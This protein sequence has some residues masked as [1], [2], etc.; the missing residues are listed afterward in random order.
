M[1]KPQRPKDG[2]FKPEESFGYMINYV[3]RLYAREMGREAARHGVQL[4]TFPVLL[5]L[6]EA[7]GQTQSEL[8]V[9]AQIEQPT[10]A[11]TLNRMERDG[12]IRREPDPHDRRAA[13]VLP[14]RAGARAAR[15]PLTAAARAIN[16]RSVERLEVIDAEMFLQALHEVA[17]SLSRGETGR[18][19]SG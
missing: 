18:A 13:R 5:A 2:A 11:A 17:A 15:A 4:G 3:A 19:P 8:A 14:H 9:R 10:M 7:E 16:A 1:A 6:W 12:L